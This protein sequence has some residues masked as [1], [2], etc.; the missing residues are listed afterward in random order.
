MGIKAR[1]ED[2]NDIDGSLNV[3]QDNASALDFGGNLG[4]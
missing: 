1:H 4:G 2:T 3:D